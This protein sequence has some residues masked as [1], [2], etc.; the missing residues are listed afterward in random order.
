LGK[1][2]GAEPKSLFNYPF[3]RKISAQR[4]TRSGSTGY[5]HYDPQMHH[6]K[7]IDFQVAPRD[8]KSSPTPPRDII[9]RELH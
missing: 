6:A 3:R 8:I 5:M 7:P 2:C 1:K 4:G 9:E